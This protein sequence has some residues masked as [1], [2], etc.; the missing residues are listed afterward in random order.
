LPGI[1]SGKVKIGAGF[2]RGSFEVVDGAGHDRGNV[3]GD[4]FG[5]PV[6]PGDRQQPGDVTIVVAAPDQLWPDCG[7]RCRSRHIIDHYRTRGDDRAVPE[8]DARHHEDLIAKPDVVATTVSPRPGSPA[9]RPKC[10]A[11]EPP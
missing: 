3:F 5:R 4:V 7:R 6:P 11:Q 2:E 8:S 10:S 1:A 9:I